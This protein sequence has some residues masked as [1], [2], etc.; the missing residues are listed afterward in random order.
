MYMY[1]FPLF[2]DAVSSKERQLLKWMGIFQVGIF[3]VGSF[4]RK[5]SRGSL[6][7]GNFLGGNFAGGKFPRTLL[8]KLLFQKHSPRSVLWKTYLEILR[9]IYRNRLCRSRFFNKIDY[10]PV[11][12]RF[13]FYKLFLLMESFTSVPQGS[14]SAKFHISYL[15]T[16]VTE[17]SFSKVPD[18]Q[19]ET[20]Q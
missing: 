8:Y 6:M 18:L 16:P 7:G 3:W 2:M 14:C 9:K 20:L 4:Q 10:V 17:L 12:F 5:F 13:W 19:T 11:Y 15:K 1:T